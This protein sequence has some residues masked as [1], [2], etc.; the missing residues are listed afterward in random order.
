VFVSYYTMPAGSG[1]ETERSTLMTRIGVRSIFAAAIVA[2]LFAG[3]IMADTP[4]AAPNAPHTVLELRQYTLHSGKRDVLIDLFDHNFV[5]GQEALGMRV[6]G[7][8]R[9]LDRGDRFVWLRSF[10]D[11]A[12][13]ATALNGFYYGP[14]WQSHREAANATMVDSD[15][16]LLLK[17][18][19]PETAFPI[20]GKARAPLDASGNGDGLIVG[21]IVYLRPSIPGKFEDFFEQEIKPQL[22]KAGAPVVAE[23]VTDHSANSFPRLPVRENENVFV[24]FMVFKDAAAFDAQRRTLTDSPQWRE[25]VGKLSLWTYQPIET[26]RLQ[27]TARSRLQAG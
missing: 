6:I 26:L 21:S 16:V 2:A 3:N 23:L 10:G 27:P 8:F 24:W 12:S 17:P 5:E 4:G 25:L 11:M 9:D 14:V 20:I 1:M 19:R 15:N 7:Q 13:R 18:V 22:Q